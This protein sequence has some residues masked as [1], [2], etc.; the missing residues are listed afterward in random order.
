MTP[1]NVEFGR[2]D[3]QTKTSQKDL[4]LL[5]SFVTKSQL[6]IGFKL[7]SRKKR[8]NNL[9]YFLLYVKYSSAKYLSNIYKAML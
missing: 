7:H 2:L 8:H 5:E 4:N 1:K 3:Y 6:I 9:T